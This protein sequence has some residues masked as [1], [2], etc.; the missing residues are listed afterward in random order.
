MNE[1]RGPYTPPNRKERKKR[2]RHLQCGT[3]PSV[4]GH[5]VKAGPLQ[6]KSDLSPTARNQAT[7]QPSTSQAAGAAQARP[8]LLP[9]ALSLVPIALLRYTGESQHTCGPPPGGGVARSEE[10]DVPRNQSHRL[11]SRCSTSSPFS[12]A[13]LSFLARAAATSPTR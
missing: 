13:S 2:P 3:E 5:P 10:R 6:R 12:R 11:S 1:S 7:R 4:N 9:T 8:E